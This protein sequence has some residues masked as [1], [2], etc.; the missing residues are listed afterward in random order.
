[1]VAPILLIFLKLHPVEK[2]PTGP[3]ATPCYVHDRIRER[4]L[5]CAT[6]RRAT[7]RK[8]QIDWGAT[9]R[10]G[11]GRWLVGT[12]ARQWRHG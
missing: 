10:R 7:N 8:L 12:N 1:M 11:P 2:G 9:G 4:S 5:A 3:A 6:S